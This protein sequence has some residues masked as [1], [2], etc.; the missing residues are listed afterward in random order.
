MKEYNPHKPINLDD[1]ILPDSV[2]MCVSEE[3]KDMLFEDTDSASLTQGRGLGKR[4]LK[5]A[6]IILCAVL[7]ACVPKIYLA[8]SIYY[9]SKDIALLQT[10]HDMLLDENKRLKHDLESLRYKFI[11]LEEF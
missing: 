9:L 3:E 8:N 1:I 11:I 2:K 4:E 10:Q 5:I 7:V 6:G